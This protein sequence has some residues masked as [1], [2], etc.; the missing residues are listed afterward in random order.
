MCQ[1]VCERS[2]AKDLKPLEKLKETDTP[3]QRKR[4]P[5][6]NK[7]QLIRATL[8]MIAE[9]GITDTSVSRIIERA[10]LSR[11]MIHL[12]FGGKDKLLTAAAQHFSAEYFAE[13][14]RLTDLGPH[15]SP[16]DRVMAVV[17]ADL[18][19]ALLNQRSARIWHA[20]RGVASTHPGIARYSSTQDQRLVATLRDA[21][22]DLAGDAEGAEG[23]ARDATN[24]TLALLEGLWVNYLTDTDGF[25]RQEAEKLVRR[26]LKGLLPGKFD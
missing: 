4:D 15:A 8:D 6:A 20:F 19:K 18:S 16:E 26:F 7:R 22:S 13:M 2:C 1:S 17:R 25:S 5:E 9:I 21:F 3:R 10:G 12:H 11:G 24:G 23:L 14:D